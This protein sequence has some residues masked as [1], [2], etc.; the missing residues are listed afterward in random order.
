MTIIYDKD[1][2]EHFYTFFKTKNYD[3]KLTDFSF[4]SYCFKKHNNTNDNKW[5]IFKN[6]DKLYASDNVIPISNDIY[7]DGYEL[8]N[9][10]DIKE[11]NEKFRN[12]NN[13]IIINSIDVFNQEQQQIITNLCY[14]AS[15][16]FYDKKHSKDNFIELFFAGD[17]SDIYTISLRKY[18]S[19]NEYDSDIYMV[20]TEFET[21]KFYDEDLAYKELF[22]ILPKYINTTEFSNENINYTKVFYSSLISN[23]KYINDKLLYYS[24]LYKIYFFKIIKYNNFMNYV[25]YD[26]QDEDKDVEY[27]DIDYSFLEKFDKKI[28]NTSNYHNDDIYVFT[29]DIYDEIG[30]N[31]CFSIIRKI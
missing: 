23:S 14:K 10:C 27:D 4:N 20:E 11:F 25:S 8:Y 15:N 17:D 5:Y 13:I 7:D 21:E 2:N 6:N 24:R 22:N 16:N 12:L 31:Y 28:K 29:K 9:I 26:D 18:K 1:F 30:E 19:L 3:V